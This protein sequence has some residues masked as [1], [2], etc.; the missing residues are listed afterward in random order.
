M[1]GYNGLDDFFRIRESFHEN[2]KGEIV[3]LDATSA[4]R[5]FPSITL[6]CFP[7]VDLYDESACYSETKES[8]L[9]H[10]LE[11]DV[12][13]RIDT[14]WIDPKCM[15][16][17]SS[18]ADISNTNVPYVLEEKSDKSTMYS[19]ST[20]WKTEPR[21]ALK[22]T[23]DKP[24]CNAA[25]ETPQTTASMAEILDKR[26]NCIL[27]LTKRQLSQLENS[28]FHTVHYIKSYS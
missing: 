3:Y 6:G 14:N 16:E 13:S 24:C 9:P 8:L 5:H 11:G 4:C 18:Y 21:D 10:T 22:L 12:P 19:E 17:H 2:I 20:D 28:G 7:T 25:S 23:E 27:G 15:Y 26:I 1:I